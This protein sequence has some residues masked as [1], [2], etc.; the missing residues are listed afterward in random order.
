MINLYK[1]VWLS[2]LKAAN[3]TKKPGSE[4]VIWISLS[5]MNSFNYAVIAVLL[6]KLNVNLFWA[7]YNI[8]GYYR[9]DSAINAFLNF[10]MPL[11]FLL[12]YF[13][14]FKNNRYTKTIDKVKILNPML[15]MYI[16]WFSSLA[17]IVFALFVY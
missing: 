10:N 8:F 12:S 9:F 4:I 11:F 5:S 3:K 17:L 1:L 15:V 2:A 14:F 7:H 13:L 6:S 16:Y